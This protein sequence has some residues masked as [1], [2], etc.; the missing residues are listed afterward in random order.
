MQFGWVVNKLRTHIYWCWTVSFRL[1]LANVRWGKLNGWNRSQAGQTIGDQRLCPHRETCFTGSWIRLLHLRDI[2]H[3]TLTGRNNTRDYG[4]TRRGR[5]CVHIDVT[6]CSNTVTVDGHCVPDVELFMRMSTILSSQ[7]CCSCL[8]ST[9]QL[10]KMHH[11]II[12]S[13]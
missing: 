9:W 3:F 5:L 11:R 2:S 12:S 1:F 4:M 10:L 7:S 6:S 8:H 13:L